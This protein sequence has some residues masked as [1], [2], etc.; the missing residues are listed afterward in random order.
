MIRWE[1]SQPLKV[2]KMENKINDEVRNEVGLCELSAKDYRTAKTCFMRHFRSNYYTLSELGMEE[3]DFIGECFVKFCQ[4]YRADRSSVTT[5]SY[6]VANSI[7]VNYIKTSNSKYSVHPSCVVS[8]NDDKK[9]FDIH[10]EARAYS[11]V[12]CVEESLSSIHI[13]RDKIPAIEF[14]HRKMNGDSLNQIANWIFDS[15]GHRISNQAVQQGM[16][17]VEIIIKEVMRQEGL[18]RAR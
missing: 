13:G 9:P 8:I 7:M 1:S 3:E 10:V 6:Q 12:E 18:I 17:K 4:Y 5:F 11:V 16:A 2:S 14:F 15:Y